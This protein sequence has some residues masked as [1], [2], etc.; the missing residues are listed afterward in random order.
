MISVVGKKVKISQM[1]LDFASDFIEKGNT[2]EQKQSYLNAA[3]T[4]WNIAILP[5]DK[6]KSAINKCLKEYRRFNPHE[7]DVSHVKHDMELLVQKKLRMFPNEKK[8][9]VNAEIRKHGDQYMILAAFLR[10]DD[11]KE[12]SKH[13]I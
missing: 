8:P 13:D 2:T 4:A 3:C 6:R 1:I 11:P 5:K 9:I 12:H 7:K 10:D